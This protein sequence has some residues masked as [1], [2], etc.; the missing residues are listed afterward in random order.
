MALRQRFTDHPASVDETYWEHFKVA[1]HFAR[2]LFGA[3]AACAVHAV[4]PWC[5]E[6]T[7]ST[8]V[9]ALCDEMTSG[10]RGELVALE[11]VGAGSQERQVEPA[12]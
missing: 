1:T 5:H 11:S 8:K 10:A 4:L 6:K 2:S 9:R 12:V 7:A 3:A